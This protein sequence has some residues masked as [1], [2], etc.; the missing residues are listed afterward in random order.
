VTHESEINAL[1]AKNIPAFGTALP[2]N[3]N[4]LAYATATSQW[5]P[6]DGTTYQGT[7]IY[8]LV[9]TLY[10]TTPGTATFT[11]ASYP[12]LR[13]VVVKVVGGGGG[14]A[15]VSSAAGRAA[16]GGGGGG[17]SERAI[18]VA[19]LGASENVIVGSGGAA[20]AAGDNAGGTGGTS[21]FGTFVSG[22]GG[23][24]GA[25][26][27]VTNTL[28]AAGGEGGAGG[29]GSNGDLNIQ[30]GDGGTT[31]QGPTGVVAASGGESVLGGR[32]GGTRTT[33]GLAGETGHNYGGGAT[34]AINLTA[35]GAR[36]GGTG[37]QG[38]A[39]IELYA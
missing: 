5:E 9:D 1:Q 19:D 30:G 24:P 26:A 14:S 27:V 8:R 18:L 23:A 33:T 39:I 17:Y 36:A 32:R 13:K 7:A 3:G 6:N 2:A 29:T 38:I 25:V 31:T 15:G 16:G 21:S 37:A 4:F 34:G 11:K 22:A 35:G 28:G 20:G 12:F 10:Y